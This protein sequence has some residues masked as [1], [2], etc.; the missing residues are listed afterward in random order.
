MEEAK[1]ADKNVNQLD[2]NEKTTL[3]SLLGVVTRRIE[4]KRSN[5]N[6]EQGGRRI[7]G[8]LDI[9]RRKV[10]DLRNKYS[11]FKIPDDKWN[12]INTNLASGINIQNFVDIDQ[13]IQRI[14]D[15]V[16]ILADIK[17]NLLINSNAYND[18]IIVIGSIKTKLDD[19]N[20]IT[21]AKENLKA[22]KED[23]VKNWVEVPN[24]SNMLSEVSR[25][26]DLL[27]QGSIDGAKSGLDLT[28]ENIIKINTPINDVI[29]ELNDKIKELETLKSKQNVPSSQSS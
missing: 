8:S 16:S 23:I 24:Y 6:V 5:E 4:E 2:Q 14:N 1:Q 22:L 20:K 3:D 7:T 25:A 21:E 26:N 27:N 17:D 10:E 11:I 19:P 12:Q 28:K 13:R 18:K 9:V 15:A 29:K